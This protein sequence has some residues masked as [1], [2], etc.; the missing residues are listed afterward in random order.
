LFPGKN[1][2]SSAMPH[3]PYEIMEF[4]L[5]SYNLEIIIG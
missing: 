5:L 3:D 4:G 2:A 1:G